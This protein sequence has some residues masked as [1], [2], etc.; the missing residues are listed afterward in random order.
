MLYITGGE[1]LLYVSVSP[2][3][4]LP[5][6]YY[7]LSMEHL[8]TGKKYQVITQ[9]V[10]NVTVSP[11]NQR[12]DIL[13][14]GVFET[15]DRVNGTVYIDE[16]GQFFYSIREQVSSTNLNPSLSGDKLEAGILF[17]DQ[18][19]SDTFYYSGETG[20]TY[21]PVEPTPLPSPSVT[22]SNTPTQT[23]TPTNTNTPTPTGTNTPTPTPT[24]TSSPTPTQTGTGTPTPTPTSTCSVTTQYISGFI[25]GGDKI[26]INLWND[27]ALTN[28]AESICDYEVSGYMTGSLGT[29]YSGT[30]TFPVGEHQI[31]YNFTPELLP[32]EVIQTWGLT[33]VDTSACLCPVNVN[34]IQ[35][36]PT[37]TNTATQTP[38]PTQTQTQT[39]TNTST[40]TPTP[41]QTP[42]N[43][44]SQTPTPTPTNTPNETPTPTPTVSCPVFTT[45]YLDVSLYSPTGL[46]YTVW[47]D[48]S[49]TISAT[50]DCNVK[51]D[52]EIIGSLGTVLDN[53]FIVFTAG[54][55]GTYNDVS[56]SLQPGEIIN[57]VTIVGYTLLD[58]DVCYDVNVIT[59][60]P[61]PTPTPTQT[62]T[63]SVTPTPTQT[64]TNTVTPTNTT[65]PTNTPTPSPTV[66]Y[67]IHAFVIDEPYEAA[68]G[69]TGVQEY[70]L[71][72]LPAGNNFRGFHGVYA[73]NAEG[74][75]VYVEGIGNGSITGCTITP[76]DIPQSG[77]TQ[78]Q[79]TATMNAAAGPFG[80]TSPTWSTIFIDCSKE[81]GGS[82]NVFQTSDPSGGGQIFMNEAEICT[83]FT[84]VN[85][86]ILGAG[87]YRTWTT[88]PV[89]VAKRTDRWYFTNTIPLI[90]AG[91]DICV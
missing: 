1:N 35:P 17:F 60:T 62:P 90:T 54:N 77:A 23:P 10:T 89:G 73:P 80:T 26:R 49:L 79:F 19:F 38:T 68:T 81:F 78:Y 61:T 55:H 87:T 21:Y 4:T 82:N 40:Q 85:S 84:I 8:Q 37:P 41:T 30:R 59:F 69:A 15:E 29:S 43:T 71:A 16:V 65:T 3:K 52:I 57:S 48:P 91:V 22:P 11:Y 9:N 13:K 58:C 66:G 7:L 74:L 32:G 56:N 67:Y 31:E 47:E 63:S 83:E 88:W 28:P 18:S 53:Y 51:V 42:T 2:H 24:N 75:K 45:Q 39:P 34:L 64:P 27:A 5:N 20:E 72:N 6:P 76:I 36:T 14:I 44:S 46:Y 33:S 86:G 12:Y 70:M 50:T 25:S